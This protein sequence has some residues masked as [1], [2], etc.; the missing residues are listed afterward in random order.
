MELPILCFNRDRTVDVNPDPELE[1]VPLS[2]VQFFAHKTDLHIWATGNQQLQIEAAI[3]TPYEAREILIDNG[4]NIRF[5]PGG[6]NQYR[7]DR[8]RILDR[9]Y[10]EMNVDAEF[11]I[12]DGTRLGGFC[13]RNDKWDCYNSEEFVRSIDSMN[14]P[15]PNEELVSGEPYYD[16]EK[17]GT[18]NEMLDNINTMVQSHQK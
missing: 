11:I 12:V 6:G 13:S 16:T 14:I 4:Y 1:P 8:L 15:E 2:W 10:E 5:M 7:E 9:L 18:Y 17:Y 3:P